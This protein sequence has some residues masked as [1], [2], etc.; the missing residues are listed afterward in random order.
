MTSTVY[1]IPWRRLL[2]LPATSL[3]DLFHS[4]T[5]SGFC[6]AF[7]AWLQKFETDS[8]H[9]HSSIYPHICTY[10]DI[11]IQDNLQVSDD[12]VV[13]ITIPLSLIET[14]KTGWFSLSLSALLLVKFGSAVAGLFYFD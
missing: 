2:T 14:T 7:L 11:F 12:S 5:V 6:D 4:N 8:K 3:Q 9:L 10:F 13:G 1:H